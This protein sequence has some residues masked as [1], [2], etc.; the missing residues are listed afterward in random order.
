MIETFEQA[1]P[2]VHATAFVHRA[3]VLI[4]NVSVGPDAS[5]WPCATLRGD[6]GPIVI[7]ASTS[8][9]DGAVV[10]MTSGISTTTVGSRV[11]VGHGAILH[12]CRIEDDCIIGMG[13]IILDNAVVESGC[14]IGAGAVI[15]P[16]KR[17]KGGSVV[18]GNPMKRLRDTSDSDR[19]WID[20]SWRIYVERTE[21]YRKASK[22][23][24]A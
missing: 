8:I 18:V 7:G 6:D 22:E 9:Q 10:H 11:T 3:A 24:P 16:G 5:I 1:S 20:K 14:I 4:G 12:G 23:P 13:S 15:P 19:E 21:Q 17:V 2:Q